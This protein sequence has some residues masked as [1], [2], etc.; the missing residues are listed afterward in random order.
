MTTFNQDK[1]ACVRYIIDDVYARA[2]DKADPLTIPQ[3][4]AYAL[5][6]WG[7]GKLTIKRMLETLEEGKRISINGS[8]IELPTSKTRE[9][10]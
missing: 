9:A 6:S 8:C 2:E 5:R 1:T 4:N 3:L 7:F 10:Q